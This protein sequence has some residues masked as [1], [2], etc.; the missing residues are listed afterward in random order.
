MRRIR[1]NTK[2]GRSRGMGVYRT[3]GNDL[4]EYASIFRTHVECERFDHIN[5][6]IDY[7][8]VSSYEASYMPSAKFWETAIQYVARW[9]DDFWMHED[10][11]WWTANTLNKTRRVFEDVVRKH[12]M[13]FFDEHYT[14]VFCDNKPR[15]TVVVTKDFSLHANHLMVECANQRSME[16]YNFAMR[17]LDDGRRVLYARNPWLSSF[18]RGLDI[19][20]Y[21]KMARARSF[22][23]VY[24]F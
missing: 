7:S 22:E 5:A 8:T 15:G 24:G 1:F 6:T 14:V 19:L 3:R 10:I 17:E 4:L 11:G 16:L 2:V 12:G 9:D 18:Q 13:K 20:N 21:Y 23:R